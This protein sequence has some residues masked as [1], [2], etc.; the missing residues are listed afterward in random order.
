MKQ[1]RKPADN[2]GGSL[3]LVAGSNR[4]TSG[5][6]CPILRANPSRPPFHPYAL[7]T[8]LVGFFTSFATSPGK[9]SPASRENV[10]DLHLADTCTTANVAMRGDGA[11][12]IVRI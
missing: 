3:S 6:P 7:T 9:T 12:G 10:A 11:H 8:D 2:V 5:S 4:Y 1:E